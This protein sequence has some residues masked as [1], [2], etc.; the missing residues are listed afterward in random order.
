MIKSGIIDPAK[1]T[2]SALKNATSIVTTM[3]TT[4]TL[5]VEKEKGLNS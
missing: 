4:D 5:V 2:I 3:L 1:V